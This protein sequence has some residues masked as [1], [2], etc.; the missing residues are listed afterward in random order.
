MNPLPLDVQFH[1]CDVY[2]LSPQLVISY[3][4]AEQ[5]PTA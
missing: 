2:H 5:M 4:S 1:I 3:V